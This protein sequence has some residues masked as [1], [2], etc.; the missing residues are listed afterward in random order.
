[1]WRLADP[2]YLLLLILPFGLLALH[3]WSRKR[4]RDSLLFSGGPFLEGLPLSWRAVI[5]PHLHWLRYPG[6]ILLVIAL[7]RPQSGDF[8]QEIDTF[9]VDI[10][11]VL[12]VSGTMAMKDMMIQGRPVNR[13]TAARTVMAD[14]IDGR[15]NDRIGL[16]AFATHS[17]TRCP[18]TVDYDLLM[19]SLRDTDL[20]LFPRDQQ[21]T[22][23]GNALATGVARLQESDARSRIIVLL[24]DGQNNAGNIAPQTAAEIA[25]SE[26]IRIYTIGF[27]SEQRT[28]VDLAALEDIAGSTGGRSFRAVS[29]E[30]L[31]RVYEFIDELEKS[32]VKV[33]NYEL[34]N[35]WF[36]WFL[37]SGCAL[38][39]VEI[40]F[41][42][43]ICRKVP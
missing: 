1:M 8:R 9:G 33:R 40:L 31:Q 32:E 42:Q 2:W 20:N 35:E 5:A 24:T 7:S 38:L 16:I 10:M 36:Q 19:L 34:W 23:I 3:L 28:D 29:K 43:V 13:L 30:D 15:Q 39:F 41:S 22:A 21:S 14:F 27:G 26:G 12:D 37:W 25:K 4:G 6:L 17:L 11:L 18:L